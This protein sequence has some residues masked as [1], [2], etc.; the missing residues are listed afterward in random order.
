M[1]AAALHRS[2]RAIATALA[3]CSLLTTAT[4]QAAPPAPP[5]AAST[6]HQQQYVFER[7]EEIKSDLAATYDT[8][9]GV[10]VDPDSVERSLSSECF[11]HQLKSSLSA[12]RGRTLKRPCA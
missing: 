4:A 5:S 2:R 6:K 12:W 9:G 7:R 3:S 1:W 11:E 8:Y 10:L